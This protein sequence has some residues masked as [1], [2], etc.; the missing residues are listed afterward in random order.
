MRRRQYHDR[1]LRL[2]REA[3]PYVP[4]IARFNR[5]DHVCGDNVQD[6]EETCDDGNTMTETCEHGDSTV[7]SVLPIVPAKREPPIFAVTMFE[8]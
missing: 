1:G 4:L 7:L 5:V 6:P 2:R 8:I 3:V